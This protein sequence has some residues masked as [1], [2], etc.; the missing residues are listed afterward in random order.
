MRGV[1]L[2]LAVSAGVAAWLLWRPRPVEHP[3]RFAPLFAVVDLD[4]S[5][6]VE[7][8]EAEQLLDPQVSFEELDLDGDGVLGPGEVEAS[9]QVL[10]PAWYV[11]G[12]E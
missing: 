5:G 8:D 1:A 6:V 12:P 3:E 9:V 10:D 11:R 4:G 2:V 7:P